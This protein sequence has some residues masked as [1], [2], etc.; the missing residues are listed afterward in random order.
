MKLMTRIILSTL[1]I[2][3]FLTSLSASGSKFVPPEGKVLCFAGQ[4]V[5]SVNDYVKTAG[6]VPAGFMTY[7]SIQNADSLK[8]PADFGAGINDAEYLVKKYKNTALQI[9]LYMVDALDDIINGTYNDNIDAIGDW[10]KNSNRPVYLRIGY[11]FDGP[12]NNY[13]PEKYIKAYH[14]IVD[15]LRSKGVDNVAYV[16]HSYASKISR[17]L[18]DWYPGDDYVDWFGISFFSQTDENDFNPVINLAKERNKPLM[19]AES[20]PAEIGTKQ[21]DM[22]WAL[23]FQRYFDFIAK[24]NIK[25]FCYINIDWDKYTAFKELR[26]GNCLLGGS[27]EVKTRWKN[28]VKQD[29][30]LQSSKELFDLIGFVP[31]K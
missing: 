24:Y 10:L 28:E 6:I 22:C 20:S 31:K 27:K 9:G 17:P 13:E 21:G 15:R 18:L 8:E 5:D 16:W 4:N 23:W 1:L 19:I 7:T 12:H 25:C 29:K 3:C 30:Y 26:W 14:Y 2:G 11:E